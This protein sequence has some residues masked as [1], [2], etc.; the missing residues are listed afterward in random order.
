MRHLIISMAMVLFSSCISEDDQFIVDVGIGISV[1]GSI[2][3]DLLDP[4][5]PSSYKE[6]DI[7]LH[8][9]KNGQKQEVFFPNLDNPKGF[10]ITQNQEGYRIGILPNIDKT[11]EFPLTLI[12]W[13]STDTDTIK[14]SIERKSNSEIC[15]KVWLN[16]NL[17]WE[18]YETERFFE[19]IK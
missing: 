6:S 18:G 4:E 7:K 3:E 16:E 15:T 9:L 8:Y 14:C 13:N 2:G 5:N 11:E 12:E 1:K 17:V 19:I 10:G